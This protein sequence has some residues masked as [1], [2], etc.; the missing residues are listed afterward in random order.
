VGR[1]LVPLPRRLPR[2]DLP[3]LEAEDEVVADAEAMAEGE[4]PPAPKED[5]VAAHSKED[6]HRPEEIWPALHPQGDLPGG[7]AGGID[8]P[9]D[10]V[11][12]LEGF[13]APDIDDDEEL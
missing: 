4:S 10:Y 3:Q 2:Q 9:P 7:C 11:G 1:R 8:Y 13:E 12:E 6:V 5:G